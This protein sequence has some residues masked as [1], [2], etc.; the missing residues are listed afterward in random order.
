MKDYI[1]R[2]LDALDVPDAIIK[3]EKSKAMKP[4]EYRVVVLLGDKVIEGM[5][6]WDD[7]DVSIAQIAEFANQVGQ[8]LKE[9][10]THAIHP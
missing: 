3:V 1:D 9:Q 5:M 7:A 4:D 10:F 8:Q 2:L 6:L